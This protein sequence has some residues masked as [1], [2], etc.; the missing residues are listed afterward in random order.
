MSGSS[1]DHV[2][3]DGDRPDEMGDIFSLYILSPRQLN[4]L[5]GVLT[6]NSC[7]TFFMDRL[8]D[9]VVANVDNTA[10]GGPTQNAMPKAM[11]K[12]IV[13]ECTTLRPRGP[14]TIPRPYRPPRS[15]V[16][17]R[18]GV[19]TF[20]TP[21]PP[22]PRSPK[23]PSSSED[24]RPSGLIRLKLSVQ[25]LLEMWFS[26]SSFDSIADLALVRGLVV[27]PL[28]LYT[29]DVAFSICTLQ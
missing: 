19:A 21:P 28:N 25:R 13:K 20:V 11:P 26:T 17:W 27:V 24:P 1:N 14:L 12:T 4:V 23:S 9:I 6:N 22:P 10:R 8:Q 7:R 16:I 18:P 3:R 29:S 2:H 15:S 5:Y